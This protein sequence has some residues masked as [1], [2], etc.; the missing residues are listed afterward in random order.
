MT[1][2]LERDVEKAFVQ[3]VRK[4]GG[5]AYKF[6]SPGNV[7][8]PDRIVL[9]PR[10]GVE[11]VELKTTTGRLSPMQRVQIQ[12]LKDLGATVYILYGHADVA[13]Y[14]QAAGGKA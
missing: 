1:T 4:L 6:I 8:V 14:L 12:R 9:W 3:G 7:G 11:F 10:G 13:S 5:K 2:E